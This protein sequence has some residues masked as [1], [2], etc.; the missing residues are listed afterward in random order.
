[1]RNVRRLEAEHLEPA[2]LGELLPEAGPQA[3]RL[4]DD[5]RDVADLVHHLRLIAEVS[6]EDDVARAHDEERA[7]PRESREVPNVREAG[8]Q[9]PVQVCRG[10]AVH[11]GGDAATARVAHAEWPFSAATSPRSAS[12]Y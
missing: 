12:S 7:R 6:D 3:G 5:A 11:E 9:Q 10:E 8:Q 4:D 2:E 1:M